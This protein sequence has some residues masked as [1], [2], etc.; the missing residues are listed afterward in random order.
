MISLKTRGVFSDELILLNNDRSVNMNHTIDL[1]DPEL[2]LSVKYN[3]KGHP[4]MKYS[5]NDANE[6]CA[7][8]DDKSTLSVPGLIQSYSLYS[9]V[10]LTVS[11]RR[12]Y[13]VL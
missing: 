1:N 11:I 3:G 2:H 7:M 10:N 6:K 9:V 8:F 4:E 12:F 13:L 5:L